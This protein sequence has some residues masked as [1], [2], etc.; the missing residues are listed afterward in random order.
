M[1][2]TLTVISVDNGQNAFQ[3]VVDGINAEFKDRNLLGDLDGMDMSWLTCFTDAVAKLHG[4][5][6]VK[7]EDYY[8]ALD[9]APLERIVP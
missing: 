3:Q 9:G 5:W 4:T 6:D 2:R 8:V 7:G 1:A